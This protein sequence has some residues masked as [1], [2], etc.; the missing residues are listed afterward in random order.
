M[1]GGGGGGGGPALAIGPT[2]IPSRC[3][4][5]LSIVSGDPAPDVALPSQ[6]LYFMPY[7]GNHISLFTL[8][9]WKDYT[10]DEI[11]IDIHEIQTLGNNTTVDVFACD[12]G[13][14]NVKMEFSAVWTL[15]NP[16][17]PPPYVTYARLRTDAIGLQDGIKVKASDHSRRLIGTINPNDALENGNYVLLDHELDRYVSN[18][19]N[20]IPRR[21]YGPIYNV[22]DQIPTNSNS[23]A[24]G[25][26]QT[27]GDWTTLVVPEP[28]YC[29]WVLCEPRV[30]HLYAKLNIDPGVGVTEF[31]SGIAVNEGDGD[32]HTDQVIVGSGPLTEHADFVLPYEYYS[33][34]E[35]IKLARIAHRAVGGDTKVVVNYDDGTHAQGGLDVVL[36]YMAGWIEN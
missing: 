14:G 24:S 11:S 9:K 35:S 6:I 17:P 4:G 5:R 16:A 26:I 21:F 2:V 10:F 12:D 20:A 15:V 32:Y 34:N 23:S 19:Y 25:E 28:Q 8:G 22:N 33:P 7:R 31:M 30:V 27:F 18:L 13:V 29:A 1:S 3:E 36:S